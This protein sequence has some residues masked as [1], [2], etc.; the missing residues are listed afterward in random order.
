[1]KAIYYEKYGTVENLELREIEKP[2]P[3][4]NEILLNV[5][6]ASLNSWDWDLLT[7]KPVLFRFWGFLK[8]KYNIPG[9]DV[10]GI[11]EQ[12]GKNVSKFKPGDKVLG[13]LCQNG[14]GGFAEF[15]CADEKAFTKINDSLDFIKAASLPQAAV[16]ALQGI[17]DYGNV[18]EGQ[19]V[20]I[21]G[22][23]GGVGTF[24]IQFAKNMGAEVTGVDK[25]NKVELM[26]THGA[27]FVIDYTKE[28]FAK[29]GK[30]YDLIFDTSAYHK[31]GEYKN[32]LTSTGKFVVVGGSV[33][34]ILKTALFGSL[35]TL[36]S[37][38]EMKVLVHAPNKNLSLI[39]DLV[40]E[41]K[42]NT[43][44]DSVY[45]LKD[46]PKAYQLLGNGDVKGKVVI[47]INY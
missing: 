14:W 43:A 42:L 26:K 16:I 19:K 29:N 2:S 22:A 4:E 47:E 8:P 21:N 9:G 20:L 38:K 32:S 12:V 45:T 27:D 6:A 28:D 24:A 36:G 1:M 31:L 40:A 25:T 33:N 35:I 39:S 46:T 15:V 30:H 13:D 34:T 37:Q 41:G 3:K 18:K 17:Q 5:K 44:I 23:G 10:A 7:G 11:V